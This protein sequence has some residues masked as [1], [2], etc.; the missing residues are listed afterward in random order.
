MR[1]AATCAITLLQFVLPAVSLSSTHACIVAVRMRLVASCVSCGIS[2]RSDTTR[3]GSTA[4]FGGVS[5]TG[6]D[7]EFNV[8]AVPSAALMAA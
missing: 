3:Y 2:F 8:T 1:S 6:S 7:V 4:V 5:Y